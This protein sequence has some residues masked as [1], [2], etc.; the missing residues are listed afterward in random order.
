MV[1]I[2]LAMISVC[3]GSNAEGSQKDGGRPAVKTIHD[4]V[5]AIIDGPDVSLDE[6][7]GKVILIVN[8]ASKCGFTGQYADLQKLY[9][10]YKDSGFTVLGFPANNFLGQ[11]PGSNE[12][13]REFCTLNYGVTFPVFGK[14]SVRQMTENH[15]AVGKG[16]RSTRHKPPAT[17]A[18][19]KP[20]LQ[21][22]KP[23]SQIRYRIRILPRSDPRER[24]SAP[25][26][27]TQT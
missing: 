23:A 15:C 27:A 20:W 7:A 13:I 10:T 19:A 24:A 8:V 5:A 14:I 6:Y 12:E 22:I 17:A 26:R 1:A 16:N 2:A 21:V 11:E 4:F 3:C 18:V 25:A 9:E